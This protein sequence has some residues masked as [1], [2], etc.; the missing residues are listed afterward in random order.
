MLN[1]D[2]TGLV[3]DKRGV[4][5]LLN[6]TGLHLFDGK[7]FYE[8]APLL[9]ADSGL[10]T[11]PGNVLHYVSKEDALYVLT[12]WKGNLE[13]TRVPLADIFSG[14][15]SAPA[16]ILFSAPG[17]IYG[18]PVFTDSSMLAIQGGRLLLLRFRNG[19]IVTVARS[20]WSGQHHVFAAPHAGVLV[21][22]DPQ[23]I[24]YRADTTRPGFPLSR[25]DTLTDPQYNLLM[26]D[27]GRVRTAAGAYER[28]LVADRTIRLDKSVFE[29]IKDIHL[30][31]SG[32]TRDAAGNYY[33]YGSLGVRRCVRF[34]NLFRTISLPYE[35]RAITYRPDTD[36]GI[37]ATA[38]GM[39]RFHLNG[40]LAAARIDSASRNHYWAAAGVKDG[41]QLFFPLDT[42]R[43]AVV[44][45]ASGSRFGYY[46][47]DRRM[48]VFCAH[49]PL[50]DGSYLLGTN[51]GLMRAR[52]TRNGIETQAL[53]INLRSSINAICPTGDGRYLLA[54]V[55]GLYLVHPD[56]PA[57]QLLLAGDVLCIESYPQGWMVGFRHRGARILNRQLQP[58]RSLTYS[59]GLPGNTVY[60][61]VFDKVNEL[62]FV[63]TSDGLVAYDPLAG[64]LRNYTVADGL[65]DNELNR[66]STLQL[67]GDSL[68]IFGTIKGISAMDVRLPF[69]IRR[70]R[71]GPFVWGFEYQA[72]GK[73]AVFSL[74]RNEALYGQPLPHNTNW[75]RLKIVDLDFE[76]HPYSVAYRLDEGEWHYQPADRELTIWRPEAGTHQI[77]LRFLYARNGASEITRYHFEVKQVWYLT[78]PA[79]VG[80]L[81]LVLSLSYLIAWL[82]IRVLK[83]KALA[84]INRNRQLLFSIIAHDLRSPLKSYQ[85]LAET[86][87][88]LMQ[89]QDLQT[90]QEVSRQ[91]N[92]NG[93]KLDLVLNNLL[94]WSLLEQK[95]LT[96]HFED[97]DVRA[98]VDGLLPL[99][100]T[101]A[102]RKSIPIE[103]MIDVPALLPADANLISLILRNLL[104]NAVKNSPAG[105]PVAVAVS[106]TDGQ[107]Q[108]LVRNAIRVENLAAITEVIGQ[109]QRGEGDVGRGIGLNFIRQATRILNG[110]LRFRLIAGDTQLEA[111]VLI[112]AKPE[113]GI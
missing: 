43:P 30:T 84:Q 38:E 109:L 33:F 65:A 7:R 79:L 105:C 46:P 113:N 10:L 41:R 66:G 26:I 74:S 37:L 111:R 96:P 21:T 72:Q 22:G 17:I 70:T 95:G 73:G 89:K 110:T 42:E 9:G 112:P 2:V 94:N 53:D 5:W 29:A 27:S 4:G 57:A 16:R 80:L 40:V 8:A 19:R 58:V 15:T 104:D 23:H 32:M 62:F 6:S 35:T 91:I 103:S 86:I 97:V 71:T 77:E 106:F 11:K 81:V 3:F 93:R 102:E 78:T 45:D 56:S 39:H 87:N 85:D 59:G 90:L 98:I 52:L 36:Q 88:Y 48:Q 82:R 13:V 28:P 108:L 76:N 60:S 18:R 107:L 1:R 24:L 20:A 34:G 100:A 68:I 54:T 63:G 83:I 12:H 61:I 47:I 75:M 55:D 92:D 25:M 31:V 51:Q 14:N 101:A 64:I 44:F 67:A 99:Y 49:G 69:N 50:Q